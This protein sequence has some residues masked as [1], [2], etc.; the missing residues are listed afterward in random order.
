MKF[1]FFRQPLSFLPR[2]EVAGGE[3]TAEGFLGVRAVAESRAEFV[4]GQVPQGL[5]REPVT[6]LTEQVVTHLAV[7][8]QVI[9][10]IS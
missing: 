5:T 3:K 1:L 4:G 9:G 2:E 7:L 10:L 6:A 8:D